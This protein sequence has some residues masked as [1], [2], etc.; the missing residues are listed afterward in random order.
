MELVRY[1]AACRAISEAV[2]IDEVKD[3]IDKAVAMSVREEGIGRLVVDPVFV[4]KH[5]DT[6]LADDAVGALRDELL[7]LATG[8]CCAR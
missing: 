5:G 3:I 8:N 6:L 1:D 4:S 2:N 7:P